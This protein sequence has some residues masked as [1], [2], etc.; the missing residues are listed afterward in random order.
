QIQNQRHSAQP[1]PCRPGQAGSNR[2][3]RADEECAPQSASG[4]VPDS[5]GSASWCGG[6]PR[7]DCRRPVVGS[8]VAFGQGGASV[9]IQRDSS[10]DL[11]PLNS[12]LARRLMA[13]TRVSRLPQ[14][15]RGKQA[16]N[17]GAVVELLIRPGQLA[18]DHLEVRE[19]EINPVLLDA[20]GDLAPDARLRISSA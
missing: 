12:L 11:P 4:R 10:L 8:L 20:D 2:D 1:R 6:A 13:R 17:I 9:E 15:Y 18:A 5:A 3:A 19:L 7:R 16:E 14:R